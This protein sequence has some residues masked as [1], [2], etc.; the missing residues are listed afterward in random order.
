MVP[1][2]EI[3]GKICAVGKKV[4]NFKVGDKVGWGVFRDN[5]GACK[6]CWTGNM[7]CCK[8]LEATYDPTFGGYNTHYQG[9]E[10]WCFHWPEKLWDAS[11]APLLCAGA[12]LFGALC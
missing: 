1:G 8:D 4:K 5:C 11:A 6:N 10:K 12:T 9:K 7:E 2:H 3:V